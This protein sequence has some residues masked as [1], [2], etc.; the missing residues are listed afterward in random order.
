MLID[1]LLF[2][3]LATKSSTSKVDVSKSNIAETTQCVWVH[4]SDKVIPA[5]GVRP[6]H[7]PLTER[8]LARRKLRRGDA[9]IVDARDLPIDGA[10]ITALIAA[11]A[12]IRTQSRWLNAVAVAATAREVRAIARLPFVRAVHPMH[13]TRS[14]L[15]RN[16]SPLGGEGGVAATDYGLSRDQLVQIGVPAMH[17]RGFRGAGVL[18]GILDTGFNRIHDAFHSVD[19]PLDVIAEWDFISN[20]NNTGIEAGDDSE[21]HKHGTWILGT[22]AAYIPGA[23][24]GSAYE[25]QFVLAKTEVVPTETAIE[26]DYYVAGLEFVEAQGADLATSSLGYIDWYTPEQLDGLTAVTTRAVNIATANGMICL[27][28]AGNSGHDEDS[29]TNHMLA[30][31]DALQGISCG[32][33]NADES[34]AG[35]SSDGP[36]ADGRIKP[37]VLARGVAV[38]TINSTNATTFA[39]LSGTSLSTPLIAGATALVLQARPEFTVTSMRSAL[40]TTASD[41]LANGTHDPLF[42]RGFGMISAMRAAQTNRAIADINLDGIVDAADLTQLLGAWGPCS[43]LDIAHNSCA[44]DLNGDGLV[45]AADLAV[46]LDAWGI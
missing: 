4:L 13:A 27:T 17:A 15:P 8:A 24:V 21:Q 11:G 30:P 40:F 44:G 46:M 34:I 43:E 38:A 22:L 1:A 39:A 16:E 14:D 18:I 23:L 45:S 12:E 6:E 37:E 20:D 28:A 25:A 35:F 5:G 19:H 2:A 10:R 41:M 29:A 36:S 26:E 7:T 32:A 9:G 33:A 31:A 42:V 3:M